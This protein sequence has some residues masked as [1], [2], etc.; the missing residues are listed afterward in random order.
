MASFVFPRQLRSCCGVTYGFCP[1]ILRRECRRALTTGLSIVDELRSIFSP[2]DN[3]K[4]VTDEDDLVKF[5]LD[6]T[7]Q[8]PGRSNVV[9]QP[10]TTSGVSK[11][12]TFCNERRIGVVPQGGKRWFRVTCRV[13]LGDML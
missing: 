7:G 12:L 9:V 4:I 5:N 10:A 6:W 11:I 2:E 13:G 1:G 8:Y 3:V